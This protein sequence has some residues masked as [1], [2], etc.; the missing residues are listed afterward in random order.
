M[1]NDNQENKVPGQEEI[2]KK[3][4]RCSARYSPSEYLTL[5]TRCD[6]KVVNPSGS[7]GVLLFQDINIR[8]KRLPVSIWMRYCIYK[9]DGF[10]SGI[11]T[12]ENDLMNSFSIPVL[13][14]DGNRAYIMVSCKLFRRID[15]R[16]KY[17]TT[18]T[19]VINNRMKE[20]SDFKI[21]MRISI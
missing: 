1:L 2:E 11:Y 6:Y 12:W 13:Y 21:Q 14:G 3:S 18:D 20:V 19:S 15:L 17:G 9:T 16:L 10:D 4:I 5:N 7:K 8:L